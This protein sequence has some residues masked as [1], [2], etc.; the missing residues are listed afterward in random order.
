MYLDGNND[1][2]KKASDLFLFMETADPM[3]KGVDK[4]LNVVAQL[5]KA[6]REICE[7]SYMPPCISHQENCA[8]IPPDKESLVGVKRFEVNFASMDAHPSSTII[9]TRHGKCDNVIDSHLVKELGDID[10]SES[11]NLE[12]FLVWAV[13]NN[14]AEHYA[15]IL[16]DHGDGFIGALSDYKTKKP[17]PLKD[18]QKTL[19]NVKDKTGVKSDV[20][21]MDGCLMG[22]VEA[23][24]QL[25]GNTR[26]YIA[27]EN[28]NRSFLPYHEIFDACGIEKKRDGDLTALEMAKII[29]DS[30]T[31][32]NTND[33]STTV[34]LNM[35]KLEQLIQKIKTLS[36]ALLNSNI[37]KEVFQ[38]IISKSKGL[39]L[40][41]NPSGEVPFA[42]YRD[43]KH[44]IQL[45]RDEEKIKDIEIKKAAGDILTFLETGIIIE[46]SG[47]I[48]NE[49]GLSIYVPEEGLNP[50]K[51]PH[52]PPS[53]INLTK[54]DIIN[55]YKELDFIKETQ[56]D[57]VLEKFAS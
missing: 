2:G 41:A 38:N 5:G 35:I 28:I 54:E 27:S 26:Y 24:Y 40:G 13:Q 46:K 25:R 22:E 57:K 49:N 32:S 31:N 18:I 42:D 56:W 48:Q 21:I 19:Q 33:F 10:L 39:Y 15:F 16:A 44:L 20:L 12:D 29:T 7:P 47:N 55:Q 6:P 43:F 50:D 52:K 30:V 17:M 34:A 36:T 1:L 51:I 14:P 11:K 3:P 8:N 4:Y 37:P 53:G 45:I 9:N 23:A